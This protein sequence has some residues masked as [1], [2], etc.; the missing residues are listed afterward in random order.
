[1]CF[2]ARRLIRAMAATY[3]RATP[4][5]KAERPLLLARDMTAQ[6]PHEAI[7]DPDITDF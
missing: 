2:I 3:S 6:R 7:E 5:V 4:A 1:M